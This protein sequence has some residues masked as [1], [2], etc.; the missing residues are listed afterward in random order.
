MKKLLSWRW[1]LLGTA[2]AVAL[3]VAG[4]AYLRHPKST[5]VMRGHRLAERMGCF[6]CHGPSGT[7]GVPNPGSDEGEV[8]AWDGGVAMMYV[9]NEPEI[10]EWILYGAPRRLWKDGKKPSGHEHGQQQEHGDGHA[11]DERAAGEHAHGEE[12]RHGDGEEEEEHAGHGDEDHGHLIPMPAYEGLLGESE[13]SD[14]V[15]YYKAVAAYDDPTSDKAKEG[16]E[17]ASRMGCF[18]CHGPGGRGGLS[19]PRSFKGYIPPWDG[20]DFD[21]VVKNDDELRKWIL[22]GKIAR[23]EKDPLARHFTRRQIIQM[24]AYR[25]RLSGEELDALIAYIHGLRGSSGK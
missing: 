22:D 3:A 19:N 8:P 25:G 12:D 15:A 11:A 16:Y 2:V 20:K 17:V 6:A 23:F 13:L 9:G 1:A 7:G 10:R 21:E 14:L 5:P 18:G 24:P 4:L